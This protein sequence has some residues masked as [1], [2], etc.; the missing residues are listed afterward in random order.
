VARCQF[1]R[2]DSVQSLYS[3]PGTLYSGFNFRPIG[4]SCATTFSQPDALSVPR[5]KFLAVDY[6][7]RVTAY[8]S[9]GMLGLT[10]HLSVTL[11]IRIV[12]LLSVD[13]PTSVSSPGDM[14][15]VT[16][17]WGGRP[18]G[19]SGEPRLHQSELENR[20]D[21]PP[22]YRTRPPSLEQ[23]QNTT[24]SNRFAHI[25]IMPPELRLKPIFIIG[26]IATLQ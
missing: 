13:P 11:P 15:G 23:P 3:Y 19:P 1:R 18:N 22:T 6:A 26:N 20:T 4:S 2:E 14:I 10:S 24:V 8:A 5:S 7:I 17:D 16:H 25:S 9:T 12:S 21:S